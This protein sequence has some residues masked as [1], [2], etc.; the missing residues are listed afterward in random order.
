MGLLSI[1]GPPSTVITT[2]TTAANAT[3]HGGGHGVIGEIESRLPG[4]TIQGM[5]RGFFDD[6]RGAQLIQTYS[7]DKTHAIREAESKTRLY[8]CLGAAAALLRYVEDE[9]NVVIPAN[10][11]HV[12]YQE[13][14]NHVIVDAATAASLELVEPLVGSCTPSK[15]LS[16]VYQ[17]YE[18]RRAYSRDAALLV[19]LLTLPSFPVRLLYSVPCRY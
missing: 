12:V 15:R 7:R 10:S 1:Y 4:C 5:K 17:W 6:T 9:F 16:S 3:S 8:L 11:L 19:I 13:H 18:T 14:L 2:S